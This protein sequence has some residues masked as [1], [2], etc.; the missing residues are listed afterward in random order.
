MT[1]DYEDKFWR[2]DVPEISNNLQGMKYY[3][4]KL[5]SSGDDDDNDDDDDDDDSERSDDIR[6]ANHVAD[7]TGRKIKEVREGLWGRIIGRHSSDDDDD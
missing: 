4:E 2:R 1:E 6:W 3:L 5:R 7:G